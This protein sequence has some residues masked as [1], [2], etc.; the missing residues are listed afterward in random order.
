MV[1]TCGLKDHVTVVFEVPVTVGVKVA[2]WP[3]LSDAD[4]GPTVNKIAC[5]DTAALAL[6]VESATLFAVIVTVSELLIVAGAL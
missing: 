4:V 5:N 6:L 2:L 1:P 3:P